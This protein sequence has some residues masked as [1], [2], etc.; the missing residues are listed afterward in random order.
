LRKI[1]P[2]LLI[3]ASPALAETV[4]GK[5]RGL[6]DVAPFNC[7]D[8]TRSSLVRRVCFDKGKD[9]MLISLNGTYYHYCSIPENT[10]SALLAADSM[11]RFYNTQVKGRFDCR[12]NP[13]PQY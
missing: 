7:T 5:Y 6:V 13:V 2:L 10:V 11:G 8:V 9:Y 1:I 12:L 4:D 3:C